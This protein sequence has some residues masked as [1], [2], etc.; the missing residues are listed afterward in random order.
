[1]IFQ[2]AGHP[3]RAAILIP[4]FQGGQSLPDGDGFL[5]TSQVQ[6]GSGGLFLTVIPAQAGIQGRRGSPEAG[7]LYLAR[8]EKVP[9]RGCH[10]EPRLD[11]G[12]CVTPQAPNSSRNAG[13]PLG[14]GYTRAPFLWTFFWACKRKSHQ[15]GMPPVQ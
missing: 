14:D 12:P 13:I 4:P 9:N 6:S 10:G 15:P 11:G 7:Q 1:M 8:Q 3:S 5:T 2:I